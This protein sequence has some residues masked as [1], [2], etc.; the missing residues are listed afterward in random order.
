M[1]EGPLRPD[2]RGTKA[3]PTL[4]S[5]TGSQNRQRLGD[6]RGDVETIRQFT[7]DWASLLSPLS[8]GPEQERFPDC[9]DVAGVVQDRAMHA[10]L[11]HF[12]EPVGPRRDYRQTG[13]QS[14]ET[15]VGERIVNRRKQKNV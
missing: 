5:V 15:G 10:V 12:E 13:R 2:S 14:F 4:S 6:V 1:W 9:V 8:I 11:D 3:A 7:D